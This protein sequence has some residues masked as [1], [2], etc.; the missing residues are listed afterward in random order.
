[1]RKSLCK[2]LGYQSESLWI[3]HKKD[4][5]IHQDETQINPSREADYTLMLGNVMETG[6]SNEEDKK[7]HPPNRSAVKCHMECGHI[8][9]IVQHENNLMV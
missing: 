1:M 9:G 6:G 4:G 5:Y 7:D 2:K 3:V 8:L